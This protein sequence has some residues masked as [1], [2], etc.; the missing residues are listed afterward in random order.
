MGAV[1]AIR[2]PDAEDRASA[3][4][5][6]RDQDA[7]L[8]P[9]TDLPTTY[10]VANICGRD[11]KLEPLTPSIGTVVHGIDLDHARVPISLGI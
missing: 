1:A 11:F 8:L 3:A 4:L 5:G 6:I 2:E 10:S 9:G 7:G